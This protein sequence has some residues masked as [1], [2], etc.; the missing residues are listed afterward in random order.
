MQQNAMM[1]AARRLRWFVLGTLVSLLAAFALL[2]TP[3]SAGRYRST[4]ADGYS[5]SALGHSGW[6]QL[7]RETGTPVVQLRHLGTAHPEALLI[8]AEPRSQTEREAQTL[9]QQFLQAATGLL[10][11]PKRYGSTDRKRPRWI[12]SDGIEP[13]KHA[14][15]CLRD[16]L[17]ETPWK[18]LELLRSDAVTGWTSRLPGGLLPDLE[19]PVQ[20]LR[21]DHELEPPLEPPLEPLLACDQGILLARHGSLTVLSDPDLIANHGIVRGDNAAIALACVAACSQHD[22]VLYDETSHGHR[23]EPSFWSELGRWPLVLVSV[24]LWL[25]LA[26]LLWIAADR[27][28]APLPSPPALAAGKQF[29]IDNIVHLLDR[30][31]SLASGL[32]RFL[33][34]RVRSAA[35]RL[36]APRSL[37][38]EACRNFLLARLPDAAV[39][40]ELS[41][42]LDHNPDTLTP[43]A[44]LSVARRVHCLTENPAENHKHAES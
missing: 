43:T 44:A 40:R 39:S 25:L 10:V 3:G 7:L 17:P 15:E 12:E 6:L 20:L 14:A 2:V 24:Q 8:I 33:R 5:I 18:G 34:L 27:F 31:G 23:R 28:G 9:A 36:Q 26:L 38:D 30:R 1:T 13:S 4:G 21:H 16:L 35:E 19:G 41:E 29:L 42:L 22:V 11:L 37:S 32:R